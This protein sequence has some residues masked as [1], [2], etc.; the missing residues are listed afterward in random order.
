MGK[1]DMLCSQPTLLPHSLQAGLIPPSSYPCTKLPQCL[2]PPCFLVSVPLQFSCLCWKFPFFASLPR[3]LLPHMSFKTWLGLF[4]EAHPAQS[5]TLALPHPSCPRP[6]TLSGFFFETKFRYC[7]PGW[8]AM[9]RSRL[10]T[11]SASWFQAIL[12]PQPPE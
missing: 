12:L 11:T 2:S 3:D 8:S 6:G 7:Y 9:V 1:T 4:W 5:P 10:T